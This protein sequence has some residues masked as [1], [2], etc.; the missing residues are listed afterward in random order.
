MTTEK[1][2]NKV[3]EKVADYM[4]NIDFKFVGFYE[5]AKFIKALVRFELEN[6]NY[7]R[8][9]LFK[10]PADKRRQVE[11]FNCREYLA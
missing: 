9:I 10:K 4:G 3:V 1:Y 2:L 8:A 11:F 7:K 5:D 6:K